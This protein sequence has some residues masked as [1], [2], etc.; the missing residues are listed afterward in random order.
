MTETV[1]VAA[2]LNRTDG[3]YHTDP[4]CNN[5]PERTREWTI[6]RAERRDLTECRMCIGDISRSPQRGWEIQRA[7]K[8]HV[9][10]SD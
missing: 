2:Y 8:A 10:G 5:L 1:L 6:D 9:E 3:C 4:E 7:I